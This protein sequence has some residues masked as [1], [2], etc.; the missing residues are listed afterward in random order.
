M[1]SGKMSHK[2]AWQ[3]IARVMI[4]KGYEVT[5]KQCSTRMTTMKRTYKSIRD[6]NKA[7]A[8]NRREWK[9]FAVSAS[10]IE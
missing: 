9:Y 8:N 10:C 1:F 6:H 2:K 3:Q 4:E 7:S 5:D